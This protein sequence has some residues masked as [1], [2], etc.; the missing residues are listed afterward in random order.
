MLKAILKKS[1]KIQSIALKNK[2]LKDKLVNTQDKTNALLRK[3]TIWFNKNFKAGSSRK[4]R[5]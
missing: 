4:S 3:Y 5:N 1:N 2:S